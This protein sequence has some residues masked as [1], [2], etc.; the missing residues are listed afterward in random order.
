M[1]G[2]SKETPRGQLN[3]GF[4][5]KGLKSTLDEIKNRSD[6]KLWIRFDAFWRALKH[7][8]EGCLHKFSQPEWFTELDDDLKENIKGA[9]K[10][11]LHG[12][13]FTE[14]Q[15]LQNDLKLL[16]LIK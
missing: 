11:G 7:M 10:V 4:L 5:E 15:N 3:L 1:R 8:L 16:G 9:K 12:L 6:Q 13:H 2:F 14:M